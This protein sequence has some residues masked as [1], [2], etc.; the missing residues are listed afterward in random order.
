M[1]E[2]MG[3]EAFLEALSKLADEL[4]PDIAAFVRRWALPGT[5]EEFAGSLGKLF[6]KLLAGV[7]K[8]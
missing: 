5:E 4:E 6:A 1:K 8:L 3:R 7:M 2:P